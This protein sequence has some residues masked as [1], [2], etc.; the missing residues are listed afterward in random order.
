MKVMFWCLAAGLVVVL[1]AYSAAL[2]SS[3]VCQVARST[4]YHVFR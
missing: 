2:Y 1:S 4:T 3:G